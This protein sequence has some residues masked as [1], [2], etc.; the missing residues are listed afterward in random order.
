MAPKQVIIEHRSARGPGVARLHR[1]RH[2]GVRSREV[3]PGAPAG[4]ARPS[5]GTRAG[6]S[7]SP[8]AERVVR[9]RRRLVGSR[10]RREHQPRERHHVYFAACAILDAVFDN[11]RDLV[12]V[13]ELASGVPPELRE[14]STLYRRRL[15][16]REPSE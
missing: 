9:R 6:G 2:R 7:E 10:R 4:G 16:A 14:R 15:T 3:L 8:R 1:A 5:P 13:V 11:L 12:T